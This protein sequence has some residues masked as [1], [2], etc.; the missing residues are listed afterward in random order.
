MKAMVYA[1]KVNTRE[2]L[3]R[4]LSAAR[5]INNAAVIR[6]VTSSMVTRVRKFIEADKGNF[7]QPARVFNGESVTLIQQYISINSQYSVLLSN[8]FTVLKKLVTP[9]PL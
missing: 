1:H 6:K 8:L 2:L 9:E 7:K 5:N 3:Q 4:I